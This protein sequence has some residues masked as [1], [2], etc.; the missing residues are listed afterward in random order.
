M[1]SDIRLNMRS[2]MRPAEERLFLCE[3]L[4]R[5]LNKG[6]VVAG[7]VTISLADV[8]LIWIGLRLVVT[9]VETLRKNMLE[10]LNSEDVLGQD[11]EY[12]LEYMKNAGRK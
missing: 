2:G 12:A 11:V 6:V 10:K 7:D 4:N 5:L 9:S 1:R 3:V 8:D